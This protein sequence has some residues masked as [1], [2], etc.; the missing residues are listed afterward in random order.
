M[1]KIVI[2]CKPIVES[3]CYAN[4]YDW[5]WSDVY[6]RDEIDII[7]DDVEDLDDWELCSHYGIN[8][9]KVNLIEAL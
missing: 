6:G 4:D 2:H 3:Q 8:Y 1:R 5:N 9:E 7:V